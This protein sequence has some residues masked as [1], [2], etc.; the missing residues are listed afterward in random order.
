MSHITLYRKGN[1]EQGRQ[2]G[3]VPLTDLP[4]WYAPHDAADRVTY[5]SQVDKI[6]AREKGAKASSGDSTPSGT[7][8]D[9]RAAHEIHHV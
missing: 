6:H 9:S 8:R 5:S 1:G 7:D 2:I 4:E 3:D